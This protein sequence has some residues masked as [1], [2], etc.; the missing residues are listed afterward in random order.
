MAEVAGFADGAAGAANVASSF[1]PCSHAIH[2]G[3]S[4]M[5]VSARLTDPI[6]IATEYLVVVGPIS[7]AV[8]GTGLATF[9]GTHET[10]FS[11]TVSS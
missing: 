4:A 11:R 1:V 8:D 7:R 3:K 10:V 5:L 6:G 9:S 2:A